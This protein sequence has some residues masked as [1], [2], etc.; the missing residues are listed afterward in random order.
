MRLSIAPLLLAA[1]AALS[2]CCST[3]CWAATFTL[4][5]EN[6]P[7]ADPAPEIR[8]QIGIGSVTV[9][10]VNFQGPPTEPIWILGSVINPVDNWPP[11]DSRSIEL[12]TFLPHGLTITFPAPI[13]NLNFQHG[14]D[15][16][17]KPAT[18]SVSAAGLVP[19]NFTTQQFE[20]RTLNVDFPVPVRS[21]QFNFVSGSVSTLHM[22]NLTYTTIPEPSA[23]VLLGTG[24]LAIA[25]IRRRRLRR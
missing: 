6:I 9:D 11:F 10:G 14:Q 3:F 18:Y 17:A 19:F 12:W 5:F 15:A 22:D 7:G 16:V 25:G 23:L 1:L 24:G 21:V 8:K 4:D 13:T 20:P 2:S